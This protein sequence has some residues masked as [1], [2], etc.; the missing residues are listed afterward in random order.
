MPKNAII[1]SA[2]VG[3]SDFRRCNSCFFDFSDSLG[4]KK[5][6][7]YYETTPII[8]IEHMHDC[9]VAEV[10]SSSLSLISSSSTYNHSATSGTPIMKKTIIVRIGNPSTNKE[11]P[12]HNVPIPSIESQC[13]VLSILSPVVQVGLLF[14]KNFCT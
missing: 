8:Q 9:R 5:I 11:G 13:V 4:F 12:K 1:Y 14:L 6:K 2:V 7:N 3:R 10:G